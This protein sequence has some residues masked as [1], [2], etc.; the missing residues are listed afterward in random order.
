MI[1]WRETNS[2]FTGT[3]NF[4]YIND[5]LLKRYNV[6]FAQLIASLQTDFISSYVQLAEYVWFLGEMFY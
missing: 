6:V 3:S 1:Y 2:K 4:K 5:R